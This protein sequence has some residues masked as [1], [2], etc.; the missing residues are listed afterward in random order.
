MIFNGADEDTTLLIRPQIAATA[1]ATETKTIR[2]GIY[3]DQA[4]P[5]VLFVCWLS[6]INVLAV[7]Y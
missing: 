2:L 3:F 4:M 6:A 1:S 5:A 7:S